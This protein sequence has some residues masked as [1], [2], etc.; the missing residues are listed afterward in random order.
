MSSCAFQNCRFWHISGSHICLCCV[1]TFGNKWAGECT[2]GLLS[3]EEGSKTEEA[4]WMQHFIKCLFPKLNL[5]IYTLWI[6]SN[7]NHYAHMSSHWCLSQTQTR[8]AA[9]FTHSA[10]NSREVQYVVSVGHFCLF[11]IWGG[12]CDTEDFVNQMSSVP[13]NVSLHDET[14]FIL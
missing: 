14:V 1:Q 10:S 2:I 5:I 6:T 3:E 8:L 9:V 7:P 4:E 12:K 11:H 13:Q